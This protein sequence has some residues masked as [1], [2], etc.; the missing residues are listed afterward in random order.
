MSAFELFRDWFGIIGNGCILAISLYAFWRTFISKRII[1]SG[2]NTNSSLTNGSTISVTVEN[3][4]LS[5]IIITKVNIL[6][7]KSFKIEIK[8]FDEPYIL[9]PLSAAK[10]ISDPFS[11][12]SESI[13]LHDYAKI[14]RL[15]I[16]VYTSNGRLYD[17]FIPYDGRYEKRTRGIPIVK[18]CEYMYN[19]VML[20]PE[21]K[22]AIHLTLPEDKESLFFLLQDGIFIENPFPIPTID[23]NTNTTCE[24]VSSFVKKYIPPHEGSIGVCV[25]DFSECDFF[26]P[27]TIPSMISTKIRINHTCGY[28]DIQPRSP[29]EKA[30]E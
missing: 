15:R 28:R 25:D 23:M 12:L 7:G 29:Q 17:T 3:K 9:A 2:F 24:Q 13:N 1:F 26:S 14:R 21:I 8:S 4:T 5:P 6:T 16:E 20:S 11:E 19:G 27:P 10:F 18:R 22:Y 30:K